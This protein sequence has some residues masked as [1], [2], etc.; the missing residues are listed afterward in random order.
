MSK[1]M[2][3]SL[4]DALTSKMVSGYTYLISFIT[5]MTGLMSLNEWAIIVGIVVAILS[6][7]VNRFHQ[8]KRTCDRS[9]YLANKNKREEEL[10]RLNKALLEKQIGGANDSSTPRSL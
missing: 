8:K 2:N 9:N 5:G 4:S 7:F 1:P 6:F 10:H 3:N